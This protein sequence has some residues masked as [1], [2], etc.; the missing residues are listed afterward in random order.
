MRTSTK[1]R[2]SEPLGPLE[3]RVMDAL[4]RLGPSGARQILDSL[5]RDAERPRAYTTVMTILVRLSEKG[6]A[7]REPHGRQFIYSA[8]IGPHEL[9]D[10][11]GRRELE[12]LLE[13]YGAPAVARFAEDL[14]RES[15][16]LVRRLRALA[17]SDE[18]TAG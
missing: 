8:A 18:R 7:T 15:P 14:E 6:Y 11:A 9:A 12:R 5:N 4:W 2:T 10:A 16:D 17:G 13:R 1:T 3:R